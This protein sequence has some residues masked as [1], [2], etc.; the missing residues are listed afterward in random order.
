MSKKRRKKT[1][2]TRQMILEAASRF[3]SKKGVLGTS[4]SDIAKD[5]G[6]SKGTVSYY[7]P[8]KEHLVYEVNEFNLNK[9]TS[10]LFLWIEGISAETNVQS[11]ISRLMDMM[12][13]NSQCLSIELCMVFESVQDSFGLKKRVVEKL[14]EWNTMVKI[15]LM[16]TGCSDRET[17]M[18]ATIASALLDSLI[19]R[20]AL[21]LDRRSVSE[22]YDGL[23]PKKAKI[24]HIC[25]NGER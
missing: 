19:M 16:K 25:A 23:L 22:I 14:N 7:F 13:E 5:A 11:A 8:T 24:S 3:F 15:G 2:D 9:M 21:G 20:S 6:L 10:I 12:S 1:D 4:F 17:D 18:H